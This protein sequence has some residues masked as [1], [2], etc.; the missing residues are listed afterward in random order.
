M[1][2]VQHKSRNR[3][4]NEEAIAAAWDGGL[5]SGGLSECNEKYA[6]W[7]YDLKMELA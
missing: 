3:E 5:H 6:D 7:G 4:T 1:E 2:T